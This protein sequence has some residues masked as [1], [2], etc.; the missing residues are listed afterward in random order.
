[1]TI[2]RAHRIAFVNST[3]RM[4]GGEFSLLSLME[5][6]N[7]EMFVPLLILPEDGPFLK[8]AAVAGIDTIVMPSLIRSEDGYGIKKIP[9][10]IHAAMN[11][12]K[13]I[14]RRRISLV[15]SNDPRVA[16]I[17]GT[18]ARLSAVPSV[19]HVRDIILTPFNSGMKCRL[20]NALSDRIV[21]VSQAVRDAILSRCV[22]LKDKIVVVYNGVQI[23]RPFVDSGLKNGS[24]A[25]FGNLTP[26]IGY[27]G[28]VT[29]AKG[30]DVLVRAVHILSEDFKNIGALIVGP[31]FNDK[32]KCYLEYLKSLIHGYG[33]DDHILFTG[34]RD[35]VFEI[36]K[37]MDL[38]IHPATKPDPLPRVLLEAM[39]LSRPI[40]ASAIGGIPEIVEN[41]KQGLLVQPGDPL[42][43]AEAARW[44]FQHP[45]NACIMGLNG[46]EKAQK[47][48][49]ISAHIGSMTAIYDDLLRV[50]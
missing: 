45:E 40:V 16:Y 42:K 17:G 14:R 21:A 33:L 36:I 26:L 31:I 34:F 20:L 39:C 43:L 37:N 35:D 9:K 38:I 47:C 2:Q 27:M 49:S 10:I 41:E 15:H 28:R 4:S 7:R 3:A 48:F 32:D 22:F 8:K 50:N 29:E 5:N 18:A 13:I 12:S 30:L 44:I 46:K 1:M 6:L 24:V 19:I 23:G 25:Q 11:L